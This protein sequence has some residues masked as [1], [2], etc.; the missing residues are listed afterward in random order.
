MFFVT[1]HMNSSK[2]LNMKK[3][4]R[5]EEQKEKLQMFSTCK[6]WSLWKSQKQ[7]NYHF[8]VLS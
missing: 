2:E 6:H 4:Q 3:Q 5:N 8:F 1:Q 7:K